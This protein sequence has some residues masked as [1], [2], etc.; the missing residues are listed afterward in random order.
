M[1]SQTRKL[2]QSIDAYLE[3]PPREV[4]EQLIQTITD[5]REMLS[6]PLYSEES[7]GEREA[8]E[9]GEQAMPEDMANQYYEDGTEQVNNNV[10]VFN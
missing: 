6:A 4:P 7:P 1:D 3:N 9:V 8:R 5:T 10:G 2:M